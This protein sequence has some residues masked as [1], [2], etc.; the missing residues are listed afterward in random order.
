[1]S[2]SRDVITKEL[3]DNIVTDYLAGL[4][5]KEIKAKYGYA[6]D[7]TIYRVITE[8]KGEVPFPVR[9]E[10][11]SH[12]AYAVRVREYYRLTV[13]GYDASLRHNMSEG[14]KKRNNASYRKY[15]VKGLTRRAKVSKVKDQQ[16]LLDL[17]DGPVAP[18]LVSPEKKGFFQKIKE[19]FFG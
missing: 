8:Y 13:P 6:G 11:E 18:N 1:M 15:R 7:G 3:R 5:R 10:G 9:N 12:G 2:M 14:Q 4:S 19:F 16:P 17:R